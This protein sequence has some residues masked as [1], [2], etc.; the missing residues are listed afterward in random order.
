MQK[1]WWNKLQSLKICNLTT[2]V[3]SSCSQP[4]ALIHKQW[5]PILINHCFI[6]KCYPACD[7]DVT[8]G[9]LSCRYKKDIYILSKINHHYCTGTTL[10]SR[11]LYSSHEPAI[12][13]HQRTKGLSVTCER[14]LKHLRALFL[15]ENWMKTLLWFCMHG[16]QCT[17]MSLMLHFISHVDKIN[18]FTSK[19]DKS[20]KE[21]GILALGYHY[22]N[23]L[24]FKDIT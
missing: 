22:L 3:P 9:L 20:S 13:L 15:Y 8:F 18:V 2:H 11:I 12:L 19:G 10:N 23:R 24:S 6:P 21:S 14:Q 5:G 4:Y 1:W 16:H 7:D 17:F